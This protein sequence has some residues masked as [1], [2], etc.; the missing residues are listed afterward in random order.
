MGLSDKVNLTHWRLCAEHSNEGDGL[1][2]VAFTGSHSAETGSSAGAGGVN[3]VIEAAR[4][5]DSGECK[6]EVAIANVRVRDMGLPALLQSSGRILSET[7]RHPKSLRNTQLCCI[8]AVT[9]WYGLPS[10][11]SS[12]TATTILSQRG[13]ERHCSQRW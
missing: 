5:L 8:T 9:S 3:A 12:Y 7:R 13:T 1:T 2:F 11:K 10:G 4:G 6:G